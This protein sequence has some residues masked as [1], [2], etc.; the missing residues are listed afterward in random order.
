MA[1]YFSEEGGLLLF[2]YDKFKFGPWGGGGG[3]SSPKVGTNIRFR[4]PGM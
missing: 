1:M 3:K 2:N 4:L